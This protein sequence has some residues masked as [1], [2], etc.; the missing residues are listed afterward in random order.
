MDKTLPV[1]NLSVAIITMDEEKNLPACLGSVAFA[2]DVVVVDSGSTDGT[3]GIAR[4][5]G[6]RVFIEDWKGF[7]PQKNSAVNK[8]R[9]E[10][11]LIIDA[12]ERVPDETREAIRKALADPGRTDA[13]SFPRKNFFHGK[14][15]RYSG[16][17]P[18]RVI[19]L[20]RRT[21]GKFEKITHEAWITNGI[22]EELSEPLEHYS[23]GGYA[24]LF[25][26]MHSR[27]TH[28]AREMYEGGQRANVLSPFVHGIAMF[29]KFYLI[30]WGFV[31][32]L[33]GLVIALSRAGGTFLKYAKLFDL[34]RAQ[35]EG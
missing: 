32:G 15:V 10:W 5:A 19:R 4:E 34:Q 33:D 14:W 17:W 21:S 35:R 31:G 29:V 20:V 24:D 16:W 11:V 18:D 30:G 6:A 23:Y 25:N 3:V 13:F 22:T 9:N 27:S 8:C 12:D 26:V 1:Q 2:T 28:M 7:G